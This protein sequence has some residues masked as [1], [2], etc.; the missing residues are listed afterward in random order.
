MSMLLPVGII[1]GVGLVSGLVLAVASKVMAVPVDERYL[2]LRAELPGANCGAC[3]FA[4]CDSY[5][6]ALNKDKSLSTSLCIPGGNDTAKGLSG[7]LGGAFAAVEKK[8]AVVRCQGH[9]ENCSDKMQYTGAKTC[10][11]SKRFYGGKSACSFGCLGL[12]DCAVACPYDAICVSNGLAYID[13]NLCVGCGVCVKTCPKNV[14]EILPAK[15]T[16]VVSC[17][18]NDKG[19]VARKNCKVACIGCMKCTKVCPNEAVKVENFLAKIDQSLCTGCNEC[20]TNCPTKAILT[21][22]K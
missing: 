7:V 1:S 14:I 8:I 16:T 20:V 15:T 12:G 21:S 5:A 10:A 6:E 17:N 2:L 19:A 4:S 13:K 11:D 9:S 3:G 18:S 22:K